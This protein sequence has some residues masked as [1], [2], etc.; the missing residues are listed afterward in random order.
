MTFHRLLRRQQTDVPED[1][2]YARQLYFADLVHLDH[3]LGRVLS[4]LAEKGVL[5]TTHVLFLSDHGDL[6]F[7]HG[8]RGKEERHYDACIRVPLI[9]A[10]PGCRGGPVC[11]DFVQ[12]EDIC[13][14]IL[15]LAGLSLP[16]IPTMRPYLQLAAADIPILPGRSLMPL[17]R[18]EAAE[19]WRQEAYCES[20]NRISSN[21]PADWARTIRTREFRY[22]CYPGSGGEQLFD[23]RSDPDEQRNLA[24]DPACAGARCDLR[25]RLLRMVVMQDYPKT[26]RDLF[27]L[28]VH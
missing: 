24:A 15:D 27:A 12:L 6:C 13:P 23:L 3:Q 11:D 22:T 9:V 21:D 20:Y 28:G 19:S 4:A 8:F 7:D 18:G 26:R 17:C 5:D 16:P 25:D 14:T 10:G 1:W 2:R